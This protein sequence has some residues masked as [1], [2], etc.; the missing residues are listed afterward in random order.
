MSHADIICC[1]FT[2]ISSVLINQGIFLLF[3]FLSFFFP[4]PS[5]LHTLHTCLY[6]PPP[7]FTPGQGWARR[8][9]AVAD[10]FAICDDDTML[11]ED[12]VRQIRDYWYGENDCSVVNLNMGMSK[13]CLWQNNHATQQGRTLFYTN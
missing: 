5:P 9:K 2:K 1:A 13:H 11:D 12:W 3:P 4:F 10:F 8:Q 7:I 6:P